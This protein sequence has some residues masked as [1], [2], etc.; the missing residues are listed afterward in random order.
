MKR[1]QKVVGKLTQAPIATGVFATSINAITLGQLGYH[2]QVLKCTKCGASLE[3]RKP[4]SLPQPS[5][6]ATGIISSH[7]VFTSG[8]VGRGPHLVKNAIQIAISRND[9]TYTAQFCRWECMVEWLNDDLLPQM[10]LDVV[11][12]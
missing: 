10:V 8:A 12:D 3:G 2:E 6:G 5:T 11:T 4:Q 1:K 9:H 7:S